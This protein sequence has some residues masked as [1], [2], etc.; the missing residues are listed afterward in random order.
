MRNTLKIVAL[1][2]RKVIHRI[3]M[4][5]CS[6]AVMGSLNDPIHNGITE[7]HVR[8]SHVKLGPKHH[9]AFHSFRCIHLIKQLKALLYRPVTIR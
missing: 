7:V 9:G 6:G 4:P 3:A 8:I 1:P 5:L 2:M